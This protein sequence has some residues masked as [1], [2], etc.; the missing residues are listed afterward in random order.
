MFV[1]LPLLLAVPLPSPS[2][3]GP[4]VVGLLP[5]RSGRFRSAPFLQ[6]I[7]K[8]DGLYARNDVSIWRPR[9]ETI[10][11]GNE[12]YIW[13]G[14]FAHASFQ[15]PT[16]PILTATVSMQQFTG[17][18]GH[19]FFKKPDK[20]TLLAHKTHKQ[21]GWE[22]VWIWRPEVT[23]GAAHLRGHRR[24]RNDLAQGAELEGP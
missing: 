8:S 1:S 13:F 6:P 10:V 4:V 5:V 21:A 3:G 17:Y 7:W 24:G 23:G 18:G 19:S 2:H 9:P 15:C 11:D 14:D 22:G 16:V 12:R 20:F